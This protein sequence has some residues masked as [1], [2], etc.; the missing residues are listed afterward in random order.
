MS[1][2]KS[3]KMLQL[4]GLFS[5]MVC[6][7][8]EKLVSCKLCG[9]KLKMGDA[10]L[11]GTPGSPLSEVIVHKDCAKPHEAESIL[12]DHVEKKRRECVFCGERVS[13]LYEEA[14]MKLHGALAGYMDKKTKTR[15]NFPR[16]AHVHCWIEHKGYLLVPTKD[17]E[18]YLDKPV[19]LK[20]ERNDAG[21]RSA[22]LKAKVCLDNKKWLR[23]L[24]I[25]NNWPPKRLVKKR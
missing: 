2:G 21:E 22:Y 25:T 12:P 18:I 3:F 15:Y 7:Q 5:P 23:A 11:I 20:S 16:Q 8:D 1:N 9:N 24:I 6:R 13:T 4:S 10:Y 19:L 14:T 17:L